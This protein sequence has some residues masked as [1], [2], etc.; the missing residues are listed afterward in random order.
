MTKQ[1]IEALEKAKA[2]TTKALEAL[3]LAHQ[4]YNACYEKEMKLLSAMATPKAPKKEEAPK[5]DFVFLGVNV[6]TTGV[7][8]KTLHEWNQVGRRVKRG[9]KATRIN[10]RCMFSESQTHIPA[11]S[12]S[13][14]ID[15]S[16]T[17]SGPMGE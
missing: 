2:K 1:S 10:G 14:N 9:S 3:R 7:V 8:F 12:V 11:T 16:A 5:T 17:V 6:E 15:I 4:K 13:V